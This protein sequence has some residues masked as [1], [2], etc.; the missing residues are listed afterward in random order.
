MRSAPGRLA[1]AF[2][3]LATGYWLLATDFLA[4]QQAQ[5]TFR[6]GVTLVTTDVIPRDQ[7]GRFVADLTRENFTV[8]EDDK[9]QQ[10]AS[11][12]V[13][14]GGRTYNLLLPPAAASAATEGLILPGAKPR[15]DDSSSRAFLIFIDDLHFEPELSPH[16][17]RLMQQIADNLIHEGD[18]V[19][20]VSSGPSYVEIGPTYDKKTVL[21]AVGK[22]RGSG[23]I[24]PNLSRSRRPRDRPMCGSAPSR[25]SIPPTTSW[26]T[27]RT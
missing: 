26:R 13:V 5:P 10:I 21:E 15:V 24:P 6:S 19:S 20:V 3:L 4:A 7:T 25:R 2:C 9:P 14:R 27:S 12:T 23:L 8:L 22:I 16:V 11:F 1:W 18:L 17:R